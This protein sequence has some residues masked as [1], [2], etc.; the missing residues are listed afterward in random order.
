[1]PK[2]L[3]LTSPP[4]PAVVLVFGKAI[5]KPSQLNDQIETIH[6]RHMGHLA[7]GH[8]IRLWM[9][10]SRAARLFL[11]PTIAGGRFALE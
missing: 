4:H 10:I 9:Q 5:Q 2:R 3:T 6:P 7:L 1:M 8:V 11:S